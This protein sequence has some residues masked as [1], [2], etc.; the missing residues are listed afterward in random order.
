MTGKASGDGHSAQRRGGLAGHSLDTWKRCLSLC[1]LFKLGLQL[2]DIES[3]N[4]HL[5]IM[6]RQQDNLKKGSKSV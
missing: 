4:V 2:F 6:L 3:Y 1:L 5:V